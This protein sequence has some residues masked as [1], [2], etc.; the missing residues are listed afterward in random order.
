MKSLYSLRR[1]A[2]LVVVVALVDDE[3]GAELVAH[4]ALELLE[5]IGAD[6]GGVA[7]PVDVFLALELVEDQREL[8]EEGGVAYD[9]HVGVLR[10]EAAQA[11]HGELV[12]L[13]LAHVEGYL[14]LEVGPAV[15]D[16]V[17]HMHRV[18]DEV[19]EEAHGVV[20]EGLG[21]VDY[22]AAGLLVIA[23]GGG[24]ERLARRAVHDLPPALYVVAGVDLEQLAADALHELYAR[25]A[26]RDAVR[27]P[28]EM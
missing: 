19:G 16:G 26:R 8:V 17:V 6:A 18:P 20:V 24:V 7:V 22:D 15:G 25:A 11:L 14:V 1:H 21:L 12:R 27:K 28:V 9:V 4:L 2:V 13:G 23:P 3:L 5:D 10:D